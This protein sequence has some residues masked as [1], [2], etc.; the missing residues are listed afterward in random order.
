MQEQPQASPASKKARIE[1]Q[2]TLLVK[3]LS[4]KA[5][6]PTRGSAGAAGYD[7]ARWSTL[8][9]KCCCHCALEHARYTSCKLP[10]SP[11]THLTLPLKVG[12]KHGCKDIQPCQDLQVSWQF[13]QHCAA[14]RHVQHA[15]HA[16]FAQAY[17][18]YVGANAL[19]MSICCR[20]HRAQLQRFSKHCVAP[21]LASE[22]TPE[23]VLQ[24]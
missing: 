5:T 21:R 6:L 13:A 19:I 22:V 17:A 8:H 7:L 11:T 14:R 23:I 2:E 1:P 18:Q 12:N 4:E 20:H 24:R 3:R 16:C 9:L 15:G 10:C